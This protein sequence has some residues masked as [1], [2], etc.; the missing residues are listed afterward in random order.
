MDALTALLSG[1]LAGL[2]LAAPLGAIG[3]LLVREGLERGLRRA[4]PSAVSVAFVDVLYC[5]GAVAAGV[6]AGPVVSAWGPWPRIVG[7]VVL[8]ALGVRGLLTSHRSGVERPGVAASTSGS[9]FR[10]SLLFFGLTALNPATLLYFAAVVTG[11][12]GVGESG[13]SAIA[14]VVGTGAA[15]FA[16]QALLVAL[17]A[18]LARRAGPAF[19]R[20][21][22]V[23][24]N[25]V[26]VL[27]G[28]ALLAPP[29]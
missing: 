17:G 18:G 24:G 28:A 4:L 15:S 12:P 11:L 27:L 14:F 7:G 23:V 5:A 29:W 20:I 22:A 2:A 1:L 19:R 9:P 3:V 25:G 10:R 26:V 16:W 13:I 6:L 21:T 8:I